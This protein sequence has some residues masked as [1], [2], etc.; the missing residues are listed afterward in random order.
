V[1]RVTFYSQ[2]CS[3]RNSFEIR[4]SPCIADG[5]V[6][7]SVIANSAGKA[8]SGPGFLAL[9]SSLFRAPQLFPADRG[10]D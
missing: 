5:A 3:R 10:D 1:L 9:D 2:V 4:L 6:Q 7:E 8:G